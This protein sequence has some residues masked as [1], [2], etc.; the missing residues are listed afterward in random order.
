MA[1]IESHQSLATHRKTMVLESILDITTVQAIGHL[2]LFWWW[3]L[4]NT[5]DGNLTGIPDRVIAKAAQWDGDSSQF[6]NALRES[7]FIDGDMIHDWMDYAGRLIAKRVANAERMR[8]ARAKN[9]QRTCNARAGATVPNPT[10]PNH[11][12][13][14]NKEKDERLKGLF[15]EFWKEYPKKV[16]KKEAEKAF[17]KLNPND[18]LFALIISKLRLLKNTRQYRDGFA[19]NPSTFIN[20]ERWNDEHDSI[21][22][23]SNTWQPT[24]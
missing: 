22:P 24:L 10:V 6:V 7:G 18:A 14:I 11:I 16:A 8:E 19:P 2:H 4:D 20:G 23:E 12:K 5:P 9:V 21:K 1:W 17:R 15:D 13:E 3:A